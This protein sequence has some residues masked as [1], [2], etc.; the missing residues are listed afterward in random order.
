MLRD[1]AARNLQSHDHGFRWRGH[2]ISRIEGLSDAV[3]AFAVTLLIV[4]L[5]VPRTFTELLETMRGFLP[6][7]VSFAMLFQIWHIQFIW[8]RRYA[9]QDTITT[10]LNATLLFVVLFFVYPLKFLFTFLFSLLLGGRGMARFPDGHVEPMLKGGDVS[11]MMLVYNAGFIAVFGVFMLLY[12]HA[13]RKRDDLELNLRERFLTKQYLGHN[14]C[15]VTVALVSTS[16]AMM[17]GTRAAPLAGMVYWLVGPLL[18]VYHRVMTRRLRT[19]ESADEVDDGKN[20]LSDH[21]Q[22]QQT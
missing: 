21:S 11:L 20:R 22:T 18:T 10:A 16:V 3:F 17:G 8:F 1:M 7:A 5:E 19:L 14:A 15:F 4:S 12:W 9:L 13:W 6:F 2:E